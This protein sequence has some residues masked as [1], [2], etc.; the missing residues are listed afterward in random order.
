MYKQT[1]DYYKNLMLGFGS[2][3]VYD[4]GCYLVSLTNGINSSGHKYTPRTFNQLLKDKNLFTGQD[5]NYIDVDRLSSV[6]PNIFTS[7]KK[8]EPWNYMNV[9]EQYLSEDYVVLGKVN[10]RGI[11]GSG[12]HFVYITDTDGV[13]AIIHDPWTGEHQPVANRYGNLGNILG[14]RVFGVK[15]LNIESEDNMSDYDTIIKKASQW[16][17]VVRHF[18]LGKP[19]EIMSGSVIK[20]VDNLEEEVES[21]EKRIKELENQTSSISIDREISVGG[22]SWRINGVQVDSNG[23][24]TANYEKKQ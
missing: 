23:K 8:I 16:D 11:G 6:L 2:G 22:Q 15:K 14:L 20:I 7:F 13:N 1:E 3:S 21:K 4:F 12:T 18:K 19:E 24:I 5:R 9:L 17:D 10:A